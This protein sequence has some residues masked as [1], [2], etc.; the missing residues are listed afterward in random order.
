MEFVVFDLEATCW[1]ENSDLLDQEI[2]EIGAYIVNRYGE[3]TAQYNAFVRPVIHPYLSPFCQRLT[4]ISQEMVSNAP[5]FDR[6]Y[7]EFMDWVEANTEGE[8]TF[9]SWGKM[10]LRLFRDD[11]KHHRQDLDWG[12]DYLDLKQRYNRM[13]GHAN[14]VGFRSALRRED[15]EFEGTPHRAIDDAYN[16]CHLFVRY[17]DDWLN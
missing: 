10:D 13:K 1:E 11:C 17:I 3:A 15:L 6:V 12:S 14:P 2:I 8:V 5:T 9:A 4:S 16:L 7:P